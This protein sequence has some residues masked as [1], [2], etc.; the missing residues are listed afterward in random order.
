MQFLE[1]CEETLRRDLHRN[2]RSISSREE[3]TILAAIRRL[4]VR[5][6]NTMV[7]R[8]IL[9]GMH[10]DRDEGIRNFAARLHGQADICKFTEQCTCGT[11]V[12][13]TNQIV[14]DTLIRGLA[15]SEIRQGVLGHAD[16]NLSLEDT[17]KLIEAKDSGKRSEASLIGS[18]N[19]SVSSYKTIKKKPDDPCT[20]RGEP[21][22]GEGNNTTIRRKHCK[23]FGKTC[24]NCGRP[25]HYAKVCLQKK[26]KPFGNNEKEEVV[27]VYDILYAVNTHNTQNLKQIVL[28]HHIFSTSGWERKN[29]QP[30]P[31]IQ[32]T[33]CVNKQAVADTGCQS[34]LISMKMVNAI[35][36][37]QFEL[38]PVKLQMKAI[39]RECVNILGAILLRISGPDSYGN[40]LETAQICYV[41]NDT[42]KFYLSRETCIGLCLISEQFPSIGEAASSS[43]ETEECM[44]P[45]RT[46]PPPVPTKV[47]FPATEE[48]REDIKK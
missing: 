19:A 29:S 45:K 21:N 3:A 43:I 35:G 28:D 16:Q 8:V 24:S 2:D 6:E 10:Q 25:H 15:D 18:E 9:Q 7:S 26:K 17:I 23:A 20:Y 27:L 14:R 41:T 13:F 44:C 31:Q 22:H 30:Q 36:I 12:N 39:N 48:Y 33:A 37:K 42:D 5:E 46:L 1:C 34:P 11:T 32:I 38:I 47:P 40:T 4:A